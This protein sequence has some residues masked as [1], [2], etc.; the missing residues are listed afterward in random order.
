MRADCAGWEREK[1]PLLDFHIT[2]RRFERAG[3]FHDITY[4]FPEI[5]KMHRETHLTRLETD[6]TI[7]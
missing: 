3:T 4:L 1:I 5:V 6:H 7:P 2:S